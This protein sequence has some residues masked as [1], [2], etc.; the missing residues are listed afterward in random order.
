MPRT[1]TTPHLTSW[2]SLVS[3]QATKKATGLLLSTGGRTGSSASSTSSRGTS[4]SA[5]STT[6]SSPGSRTSSSTRG[7]VPGAS[8]LGHLGE[9]S[10]RLIG[11]TAVRKVGRGDGKGVVADEVAGGAEDLCLGDG[12]TRDLEVILLGA[13]EA[14]D[15]DSRNHL[16]LGGRHL[17]DGVVDDGG[18]LAVAAH[19]DG[20]LGALRG[21]EVHDLEGRVDGLV[22]GVLGLEVGRQGGRVAVLGA[23]ALAGDLVGAEV[24]LDGCAGLRADD[25]ALGKTVSAAVT[26]SCYWVEKMDSPC[27]RFP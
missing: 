12:V 7:G 27:S 5:S 15:D 8:L 17:L 1:S 20:G 9:E 6:S 4:S 18:A 11:V 2:S 10:P 19:D 3:E 13:G 23:D 16:L 21:G 14:P 24:V 22:V 26:Q 25:G